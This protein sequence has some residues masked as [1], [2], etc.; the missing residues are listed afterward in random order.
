ML[1]IIEETR[2]V[3]EGRGREGRRGEVLGTEEA[4]MTVCTLD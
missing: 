4:L 2:G 1:R 3:G